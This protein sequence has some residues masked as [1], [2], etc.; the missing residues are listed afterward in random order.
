ML[1]VRFFE[2]VK[3][4]RHI[5]KLE[6]QIKQQGGSGKQKKDPAGQCT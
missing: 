6:R 1:Q 2:R 3:I 4:E 5:Q